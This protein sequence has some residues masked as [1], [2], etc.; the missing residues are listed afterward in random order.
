[1]IL[2]IQR[3]E[4]K[5]EHNHRLLYHVWK[6]ASEAKALH[7]THDQDKIEPSADIYTG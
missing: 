6:E 5:I 2:W 3:K 1:M 4:K 7:E